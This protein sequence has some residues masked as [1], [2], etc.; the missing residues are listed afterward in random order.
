MACKR[1]IDLSLK[2]IIH[3]GEFSSYKV[4]EFSKLL[5]KDIII[6]H[7]LLKNDIGLHEYMLVTDNLPGK[8]KSAGLPS[9]VR[10]NAGKKIT[11]SGEVPYSYSLLT[12]LKDTV[13]PDPA[14]V[15]GE[16]NVVKLVSVSREFDFDIVDL[17]SVVGNFSLRSQWEDGIC[18]VDQVSDK[19]ARVGT[20]HRCVFDNNSITVRYSFFSYH[21]EK[22]IFCESANAV[23]GDR[24]YIFE[25]TGDGKTRLA[26]ELYME[27]SPFRNLMFNFF[28]KEKTAGSFERSL[29]NLQN[30]IQTGNPVRTYQPS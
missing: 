22:I 14:P 16:G 25:K 7:Q 11:E 10:W 21:P 23:K 19:I 18:R 12:P 8:E 3:Y 30:F 20:T 4:K 5:G 6:A 29:A 28:Q 1:A 17:L 13:I 26:L 2:V 27:K 15:P 24:Y 9:W